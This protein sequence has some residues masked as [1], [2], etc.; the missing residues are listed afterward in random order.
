M[1]FK[2][3]TSS[4]DAKLLSL[5]GGLMFFSN[6]S[7]NGFSGGFSVAVGFM[8]GVSVEADNVDTFKSTQ[9]KDPFKYLVEMKYPYL[10][11]PF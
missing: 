5:E 3:N 10:Q 11:E 6:V 8:T 9:P 7:S 4:G 2:G 1:D